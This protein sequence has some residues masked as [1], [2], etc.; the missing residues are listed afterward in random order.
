MTDVFHIAASQPWAIQP[1]ALQ[2]VLTIADRMGDPSALQTRDGMKLEDTRTVVM[3][4]GVAVI[5]VR[6]PI[7]RYANLFSDISGATSTQYIA[8]DFTAALENPHIK[9][10]VLDLNSPGGEAAGINELAK[11]IHAARARKRIVAYGGGTMASACYWLGSAAHEI[12]IDETAALGSIGVVMSYLDTSERDAKAGIR[13][14]EIVSSQSPD[15]RVDPATDTGRAKVQQIVDDLAAVFVESVAAYRG[16]KVEDVLSDFGRGGVLIGHA[17]IKARMADRVG[18][19]EAVIAELAGSASTPKRVTAMS[20]KK[21]QVTVSSTADLRTAL[22][23]G[24]TAEQIEIA[25]PAPAA[26]ADAAAI[27]KAREEGMVE[28]RKA[29]TDEAVRAERTRIRELQ[30]LGRAGFEA[31][32]SAAIENG[33]TPATFALALVTAAKERGVTLDSLRKEA[34]DAKAHANAP[35][36]SKN[37]ASWD[38]VVAKLGG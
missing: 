21:G 16:V 6:G 36:P 26:S 30:A 14:V 2:T 25:T 17:A 29:A 35:N 20:D 23:A 12:V 33:D 22:E 32:L 4:D 18:S 34:P 10:I 19:L 37:A 1:E 8:R 38:A 5:P 11:M 24:Y 15:K 28:G 3:R 13:H 9:G 7:F 27:A 31:E